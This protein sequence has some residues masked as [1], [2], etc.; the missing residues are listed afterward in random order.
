MIIDKNTGK[1]MKGL[2]VEKA[3]PLGLRQAIKRDKTCTLLKHGKKGD[4]LNTFSSM[5]KCLQIQDKISE[6]AYK[7]SW[8]YA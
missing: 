5:N 4:D 8:I 3:L 6:K 7:S 2:F 1:A